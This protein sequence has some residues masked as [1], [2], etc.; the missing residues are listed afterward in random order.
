MAQTHK[1]YSL[2]PPNLWKP[3]SCPLFSKKRKLVY[4]RV[5]CYILPAHATHQFLSCLRLCGRWCACHTPMLWSRL[6]PLPKCAQPFCRRGL[7]LLAHVRVLV[8]AHVRVLVLAHVRVLA[9]SYKWSRYWCIMPLHPGLAEHGRFKE[10]SCIAA[11][12]SFPFIEHLKLWYASNDAHI[13]IHWASWY[14]HSLSI[15]VY[16]IHSD[17]QWYTVIHSDTQSYT[18]IHSNTQWYTV[19]HSDTQ[20]YTVIHSDTQW[21]TVIY[22]NTQ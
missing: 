9:L 7:H 12:T 18:V 5:W 8:L 14:I 6:Q 19:I 22:S 1:Q 11:Y 17:T 16:V 10:R 13:F 3:S 2:A 15:L 21:Y 20:W 4:V